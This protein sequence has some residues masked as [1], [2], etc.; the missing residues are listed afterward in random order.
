M[1]AVRRPE[2]TEAFVNEDSKDET[3]NLRNGAC[4]A[5]T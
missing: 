4:L 2:F 3:G 5:R 1:A